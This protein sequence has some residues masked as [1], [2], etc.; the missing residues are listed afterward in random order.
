M[1]LDGEVAVVAPR[2]YM[3][4]REE[5]SVGLTALVAVAED[6]SYMAG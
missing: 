2:S 1:G 6:V 5:A 3:M 4:P